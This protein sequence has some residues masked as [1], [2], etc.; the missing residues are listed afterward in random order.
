[1]K[2]VLS[3]LALTSLVSGKVIETPHYEVVNLYNSR[4]QIFEERAYGEVMWV[5]TQRLITDIND[6]DGMFMKLFDY[7]NGANDRHE[8]IDMT[9][10]VST[11][12]QFYTKGEMHKKMLLFDGH[13][14]A[15]SH[16]SR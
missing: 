5:C 11:K 9:V 2:T 8:W 13:G 1:M 7:L 6:E 16:G 10:P 4:G 3:L 14:R 15:Q 12:R